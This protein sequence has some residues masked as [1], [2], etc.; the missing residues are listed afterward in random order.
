M[1]SR[2]KKYI[3]HAVRIIAGCFLICIMKETGVGNGI[4]NERVFAEKG[5]QEIA[6]GAVRMMLPAL[7][8]AAEKDQTDTPSKDLAW[9]VMRWLWPA[10]AF[11]TEQGKEETAGEDSRTYAMILEK[12]ENDEN[13]VDKNGKLITQNPDTEEKETWKTPVVKAD[14]SMEKLRDYE[15]LMSHF[16]TVDSSTMA[17]EGLI[18]A[19][20]LMGKDMK[21]NPDTK[22]AKVLI[23]H[24]HSQEQFAD[25][26]PGDAGTSIV[27]MGTYLSELLNQKY[28]ISTYHH[29]GVYDLVN[30]KLDRSKAY[31]LAE[32]DVQK[33]VT[34]IDGKP[35]AQI[36]FFNGLS[37]TRANGNISYL[38]NP[39]LEDN[40]AFSLQMEIAAATYYPGFARHIFL[41]AY[42][43]NMH[44]K[45]KTLLIEAGAQTNTVEEMRNAMEILA[46][47]LHQVLS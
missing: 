15:Y 11:M 20:K 25:S 1:Q 44:F 29:E 22:G 3:Q 46:E 6:D 5:K 35:T 34:E 42:R 7:V 28:G 27:G 17:D 21:L 32:P 16:Y 40:L 4:I 10:G 2:C 43:Y 18:N 8:Y 37:R 33:M 31:Q 19:D 14:I 13:A 30:G 12:Q 36:M 26:V 23:Y 41:R 39:Y 47:L 9:A 38:S 45:P 24:T